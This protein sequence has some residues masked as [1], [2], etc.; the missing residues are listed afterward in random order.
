MDSYSKYYQQELYNLRQ[1]AK[2]FAEVHPAMAPMLSSQTSDPD[3]ERLLEGTAFLSGLLRQ[4][5]DDHLPE[6]IHAL[7]GFV[8]P[9]FLKTIPSATLVH[10]TPHKGLQETLHV[11]AGTE[12]GA[13]SVDNVS[14]TFQTCSDCLVQPLEIIS[15]NSS[16]SAM[17][18]QEIKIDFNLTGPG[19]DVWGPHRIPLFIGG[20]YTRAADIFYLIT[21]KL[22]RIVVKN[23]EGDKVMNLNANCIHLSAFQHDS[24]LLPY[25]GNSFAGY[26]YLQEYFLLP[27]KF[28]T[29]DVTGL[30][31]WV[32]RGTDKAFSLC[33]ELEPA[34]ITLPR[35]DIDSFILSTVPAI[36]LFSHE[37]E[38]I[39]LDHRRDKVRVIPALK[40]DQRPEVYSINSVTGYSRGAMLKKEYTSV[41]FFASSKNG[42]KAHVY[43]LSHSISPV[44]NR[45]QL[46]LQ[47]AYPP[48]EESIS[49]ETLSIQLTCTNGDLPQQLKPGDICIPS[50]TTPELIDFVN[51]MQ[52]TLPI[53]PPLAG[54]LLWKLLSHLSLNLM[55]LATVENLVELLELYIFKHDRDK[56]RIS[57]NEK[58]LQG[59]EDFSVKPVNRLFKGQMMRG[60]KIRVT[61]RSDYFAGQGD[62]CLFGMILETL[63]C[64]YCSINTFVQFEIF[65]SVSGEN[66]A[67]P[68]RTGSKLLM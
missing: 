31:R 62:F 1:L 6:V 25:P 37:A 57:S 66:Y 67:W 44:H 58:R 41:S 35:L 3:V 48:D 55:S 38:P 47:F 14:A 39:I 29:F 10:F 30:D 50:S 11:K 54:G 7:T 15:V 24:G 12:L 68:I 42:Q 20:S 43:S 53:D 36:N 52:P 16:G 5:I 65:D 59:I 2:E 26:R 64:E 61:A 28:L 63:F 22:R 51:I 40:G 19:L 18:G 17:R 27:H 4:K 23:A 60:Q 21:R 32:D 46:A 34:P 8:F 9:H 56:S 33:F 13:V 45:P 49:E